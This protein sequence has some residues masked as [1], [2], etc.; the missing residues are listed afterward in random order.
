MPRFKLVQWLA[1]SLQISL[2]LNTIS[3]TRNAQLPTAVKERW[4]AYNTVRINI[5]EYQTTN[6]IILNEAIIM[7]HCTEQFVTSRVTQ[8]LYVN[9]S[10]VIES[11]ILIPEARG[12]PY[13]SAYRLAACSDGKKWL[14][15]LTVQSSSFPFVNSR[16]NLRQTIRNG[17]EE[18]RQETLSRLKTSDYLRKTI[19]TVRSNTFHGKSIVLPSANAAK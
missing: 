13:K 4:C 15:L 17:N 1:K 14:S 18:R 9:S 12:S 10:S 8:L 6:S 11:Q 3:S 7:Q 16:I 5:T 19:I 2:Q